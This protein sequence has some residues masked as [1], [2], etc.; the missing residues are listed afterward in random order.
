[1]GLQRRG[2]VAGTACPTFESRP[3]SSARS[4]AGRGGR[5]RSVV[6][7]Q[8]LGAVTQRRR[9]AGGEDV[10]E[11]GL[12]E[13]IGV[14]GLRRFT[15]VDQPGPQPDELH[16][17]VSE[18]CEA[19]ASDGVGQWSCGSAQQFHEGG[20]GGCIDQAERAK[21]VG[22]VGVA[23]LG[24]QLELCS[25]D[26]S[27]EVGRDGRDQ[28]VEQ[29]VEIFG[30]SARLELLDTRL[31]P[32]LGGE[33]VTLDDRSDEAPAIAEVVANGGLVL[34]AGGLLDGLEF[35]AVD[36]VAGEKAGTVVE[37][38][39]AR[40]VAGC[41]SRAGVVRSHGLIVTPSVDNV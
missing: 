21:A 38:F 5:C 28:C 22:E 2:P 16:D 36:A 26:R 18:D 3:A 39:R 8:C 31:A 20:S 40:L 15:F 19:L 4:E 7:E 17:L 33:E 41:S 13:H 35:D 1:M 29:P 11:V 14:V 24:G 32:L 9:E 6:A 27:V 10:D 34:G 25:S 37:Q 12:P 23:E 30:G